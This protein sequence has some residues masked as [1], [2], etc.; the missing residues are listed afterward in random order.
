MFADLSKDTDKYHLL[1][2]GTGEDFEETKNL[3]KNLNIENKIKFAGVV[4]NVNE[5]L[6]MMDIFIFPS[7]FEGLGIAGIEAQVSGLPIILSSKIPKDVIISKNAHVLPITDYKKW[8]QKI[9]ELEKIKRGQA[10]F[11][12][13]AKKYDNK[14]FK[15]QFDIIIK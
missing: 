3:A 1:L 4:D 12:E 6:Q 14:M 10:E 8:I 11:I 9:K 5:Y 2:I 13:N 15:E 7:N